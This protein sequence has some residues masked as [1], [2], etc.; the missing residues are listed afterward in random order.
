M[1]RVFGPL[2]QRRSSPST[3]RLIWCNWLM[4]DKFFSLGI[5]IPPALHH[6]F[7]ILPLA[8]TFLWQRGFLTKLFASPEKL[9]LTRFFFVLC[10]I[11]KHSA[12]CVFARCCFISACMASIHFLC[13]AGVF[14]PNVFLV[15]SFPSPDFQFPAAFWTWAWLVLVSVSSD[16]CS[17]VQIS[18]SHSFK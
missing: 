11:F 18:L 8:H 1:F 3:R 6:A 16:S 4:I 9:V 14:F 13:T 15:V 7:S 5:S 17:S 12:L 2:L 10:F